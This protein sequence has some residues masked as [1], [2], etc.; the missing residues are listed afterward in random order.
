IVRAEDAAGRWVETVPELAGDEDDVRV[1]GVR[2]DDVVVEALRR[3]VVQ[4]AVVGQGATRRRR[5]PAC[6]LVD[7][8]KDLARVVVAGVVDPVETGVQRRGLMGRGGRKV[9]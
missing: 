6:P 9:E 7:G 8:L 5:R 4:D 1:G 3:A 2:L